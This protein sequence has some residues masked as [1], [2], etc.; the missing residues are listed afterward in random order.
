MESIVETFWGRRGGAR[1]QTR[2]WLACLGA[3]ALLGA[4]NQG[5]SPLSV[6]EKDGTAGHYGGECN[7]DGSCDKGLVCQHHVCKE[8]GD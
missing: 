4:C 8:A 1:R 7:P 3:L 2:R 6:S 5:P